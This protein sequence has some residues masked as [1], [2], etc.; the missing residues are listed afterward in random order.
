MCFI[1]HF[2]EEKVSSFLF[3]C[4]SFK[5]FLLLALVSEFN[6]FLRSWW[7][8]EVWCFDDTGRDSWDWVGP[9]AWGRACFNSPEWGGGFSPV[10]TEPLQVVLLLL[11]L[12]E[13]R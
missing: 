11:L 5:Y 8:M 12:F 3:S 7:S 10:K 1:F 9:P 2:S 6:C 4:I 13:T